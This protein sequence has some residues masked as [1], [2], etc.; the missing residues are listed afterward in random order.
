[1]AKAPSR[2]RMIHALYSPWVF[3]DMIKYK[4]GKQNFSEV[5]MQMMNFLARPQRVKDARNGDF[6][7]LDPEREYERR[8]MMVSRGHLKTTIVTGYWLWRFYRN[9]NLRCLI[10]CDDKALARSIIRQMTVY[11]ID[12]DLQDRVWHN[13][14]HV[15]GLLVPVVDSR[16]K[17]LRASDRDMFS[18]QIAQKTIWNSF[19]IQ[20]IRPMDFAE[21][22]LS[23]ASVGVTTTGEHY[24]A[25]HLDDIVNFKNSRT[26]KLA[27]KIDEW[28]DDMESIVDPPHTVV[29]SDGSNGLHPFEEIL[30][31][32]VVI[33]GTRYYKHDYYGR[34]LKDVKETKVKTFI[35]NIY[36][37]GKDDDDGYTYPEKF[38]RA[39]VE[40]LK[41]RLRT[42]RRFAA[43]Y[44]NQII[45][46]DEKSFS[47][48]MVQIVSMLNV[49]LH[50]S[51]IVY[52]S[53]QGGKIAVKPVM[54]IDPAISLEDRADR[55]AIVVGA[56]DIAR[57]YYVFEAVARRMLPATTI[58]LMYQIADKWKISS[59]IVEGGVGFQ[60]ALIH[61]IRAEF[62]KRRPLF[63]KRVRPTANKQFKIENTLE[64]IISS[65]KL[66]ATSPAFAAFQEE[67]DFFPAA[68]SHDDLIDA[69]AT[70]FLDIKP[71]EYLETNESDKGRHI[72]INKRYGGVR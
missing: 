9:P 16:G 15:E 4:G 43:Q 17:N 2:D 6:S 31:N 32:E 42:F 69:M 53:S 54:C 71:V 28:A 18:E 33:T 24:D 56:V 19:Q 3:L 72:T 70:L 50:S 27:E 38:N 11:F 21:P 62:S 40:Q 35:R 23:C 37:N 30:G 68:G 67:L 58:D 57:N 14:P 5:H 64:P 26:I 55:T 63:I 10:G 46:D 52:I 34:V 45:S 60:D 20:L 49:E 59:V 1:M 41:K 66:F 47:S 48:D 8:F 29:V 12:L 51:G 7:L 36:K 39:Y 25:V 61:S 13:R 65:G 44:L 22:S